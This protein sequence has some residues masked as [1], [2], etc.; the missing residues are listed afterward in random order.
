MIREW[1]KELDKGILADNVID[2]KRLANIISDWDDM[3]KVESNLV[4]PECEI[5]NPE[6]CIDDLK[7]SSSLAFMLMDIQES[8]V[9]VNLSKYLLSQFSEETKHKLN[10]YYLPGKSNEV[11]KYLVNELNRLIRNKTLYY[12]TF[13]YFNLSINLNWTIIP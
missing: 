1:Q 8:D 4:A 2:I 5:I 3:E 13:G 7:T 12:M 10:E 11:K 9:Q 6:L